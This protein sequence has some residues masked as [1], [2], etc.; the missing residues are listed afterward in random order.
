[1][2]PTFWSIFPFA[3]K[4]TVESFFFLLLN[5]YYLFI[6]K[7]LFMAEVQTNAYIEDTCNHLYVFRTPTSYA[8]LV[9]FSTRDSLIVFLLV[10]EEFYS[11]MHLVTNAIL[12]GVNVLFFILKNNNNYL[13]CWNLE[14]VL[15]NFSLKVFWMIQIKKKFFQ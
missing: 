4:V 3:W 7:L 8:S 12:L 11:W 5:H 9:S 1:M 14:A 10:L 15:C 13:S 2:L 6:W